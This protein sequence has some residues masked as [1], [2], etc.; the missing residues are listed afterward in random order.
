M[1][2]RRP[3]AL[4]LLACVLVTAGSGC[5]AADHSAVVVRAD[6]TPVAINCGTYISKVTV[7]DADSGRV[8]WSAAAIDSGPY[9]GDDVAEVVLGEL[10][11]DRWEEATPL[12]SEFSRDRLLFE[13]QS[14]MDTTTIKVPASRSSGDV[15]YRSDGTE[16]LDRWY[17]TCEGLP[18][19]AT[20]RRVVWIVVSISVVSVAVAAAAVAAGLLRRRR[21]RSANRSPQPTGGAD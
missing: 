21:S 1:R 4:G 2:R 15:V 9:G 8:V 10:P 12:L 14:E 11:S 3:W 7:K 6:G 13:I 19:S 20:V 5:T 18:S 17:W 16:S